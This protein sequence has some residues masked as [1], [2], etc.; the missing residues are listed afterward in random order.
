MYFVF[1]RARPEHSSISI[2]GCFMWHV[3]LSVMWLFPAVPSVG[4]Q[5]VAMV[6][7]HVVVLIH[8]DLFVENITS[9]SLAVLHINSL[10][11]SV[12]IRTFLFSAITMH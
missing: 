3:A 7:P 11:F 9:V 10:I 5:C 4:L 12:L 8:L 1:S 6:F 2:C